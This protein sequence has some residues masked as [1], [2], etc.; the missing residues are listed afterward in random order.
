MRAARRGRDV[1][2]ARGRRQLRPGIARRAAPGR[3][4]VEPR[5]AEEVR[6]EHPD[7]ARSDHQRL[8]SSHV[9]RPPIARAWRMP[10]ADRRR[11]HEHAE[12][13][14]RAR[15]PDQL[16]RI[17]RHELACEPVQA[18]DPALAVVAGEA[19]VGIVLGAGVAVPHERRTVAQTRSPCE[20]PCPSD[21][22][23]ASS[24]CP[25]ISCSSPSGATPNC[26][27]WISR[28]VPHTPTR[29]GRTAPR[30]RAPRLSATSSTFV[31]SASPGSVTSACIV[32]P[33]S[34]RRRSSA[35]SRSTNAARRSEVQD[36]LRD[37]LRLA[38][39]AHRLAG[40][41]VVERLAGVLTS[42]RTHGEPTVPG[43]PR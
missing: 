4:D 29:N 9:W 39:A 25:R 27:S 28:S 8:L 41:Q 17:L 21:S 5:E 32:T 33:R 22:T 19:R 7:R 38:E 3:P 14:E 35:P 1:A 11:L 16:L 34:A 12:P 18:R 6:R 40:A 20:N 2:R 31:D 23:R 37:L 24:S 43:R 15:D 42:R 30:R 13:P 10:A 36:R 26:P